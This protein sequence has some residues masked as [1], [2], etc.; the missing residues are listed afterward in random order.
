VEAI[1]PCNPGLKEQVETRTKPE[2]RQP[3]G[4]VRR[5]LLSTCGKADTRLLKGY[6]NTQ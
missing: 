5:V 4:S 2:A 1:V 3:H 6:H